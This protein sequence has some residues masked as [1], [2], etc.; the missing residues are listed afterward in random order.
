[1][2][3][4]PGKNDR[5]AAK[6]PI[7]GRA[8]ARPRTSFLNA[9]LR[10]RAGNVLPIVAAGLIPMAA[11]VGGAVDMSRAYMVK[12]RLQQACDA[13]VL[14]GRRAM[15]QGT[16]D[17][18][19]RNAADDFFDVNFSDGYQGTDT[20]EFTSTN[21][22]GTSKVEGTASVNVPTA[23]MGMFGKE[24]IPVEVECEAEL[25]VSNSD[26]TFVL[27][28]TGSMSGYISNGNGGY[29]TRISAL[30]GAVLSFYDVL[31]DAS[32]G[33]NARIR[34]GFV[35]YSVNT[36]VGELIYDL[37]PQYLVGGNS[38]ETWDYESRRPIWRVE[39]TT[40]DVTVTYETYGTTISKSK[41][42]DYGDNE[43]FNQSGG[44]NFRPNPEG[45]PITY[46]DV[47]IEYDR[48]TWGGDTEP[49][50]GS[51]R[52]TCVRKKTRTETDT[53]VSYTPDYQPG[54]TFAYYE[55]L[56]R[57]Y[58]VYDFLRS[59]KSANPAVVLPTRSSTTYDRWE[60]CIEERDTVASGSFSYVPGTG[61]VPDS[62]A[63]QDY[64]M[65]ID[66][67]PNSTATKWRPY[68]NEVYYLRNGDQYET[69][70]AKA[71]LL[72][73][74]TRAQVQTYVNGLSTGGNTYHDIGL[75]WGGRISSPTGIFSANVTA[76][77]NNSGT[78]QRHVI[79]MTDGELQPFANYA[80]AW[81]IESLDARVTGGS[82][83]PSDSSRHRSRTLALCE[84]IKGKGLRLWV[85]AFGTSLTDDLE[86]CASSGSAF[87]ATNSDQLETSFEN[88]AQQIA[89]LRLTR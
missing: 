40:E 22:S 16:Y 53:Q 42:R 20:L 58:D 18:A 11:M 1:M 19:A 32:S 55:Y 85:I 43:D 33:S 62:G 51:G 57:T 68:W 77:P 10:S 75:V 29:E 9:L 35:P 61:V 2:T 8:T 66:L 64:D 56:E 81:G 67:V 25:N 54:A 88:I 45:T 3:D 34:Y 38:G 50:S 52:R 60:G 7:R 69:C 87:H 27:D 84:A 26:I 47:T 5:G 86:T 30:R 6:S 24:N 83:N 46:G 49:W 63:D 79:F 44:W 80:A 36:N 82:N 37:N 31:A 28:T 71:R 65:D 13:G 76:A 17:S 48:H 59:I 72:D 74:M 21:P 39:T 12:A 73:E 70:P 15:A 14:A 4:I 23:I 41:C 78:V 89:E